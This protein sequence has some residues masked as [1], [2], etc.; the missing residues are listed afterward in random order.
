MSV[1]SP[2]A[3]LGAV[4]PMPMRTSSASADNHLPG[5]VWHGL[6]TR[7]LERV[8]RTIRAA[9]EYRHATWSRRPS[10]QQVIPYCIVHHPRTTPTC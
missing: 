5:A 8:L 4:T 1:S 7:G 2:A 9:S 3:A 10:Q 6:V